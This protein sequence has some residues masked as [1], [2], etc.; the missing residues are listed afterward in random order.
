MTFIE[1]ILVYVV[2]GQ[3]QQYSCC[4]NCSPQAAAVQAKSGRW[5]LWIMYGR[6]RA[7]GQVSKDALFI[8]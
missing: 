8:Q 6:P 2:A 7:V 3:Y 1:L 5:G 4:P